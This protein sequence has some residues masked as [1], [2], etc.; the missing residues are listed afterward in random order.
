M[1]LSSREWED[2]KSLLDKAVHKFLG[3]TEQSLVTAAL[4]CIDKGYDKKK[5]ISK[6][7]VFLDD[8]QAEKFSEKLFDVWDDYR[9]KSQR[10]KR[11]DGER[12]R[13]EASEKKKRRFVDDGP[14]AMPV[15]P[16][17]GNP[18]PGQLTG[19][20]IKEMM[21]NAKSMIN[22]RKTQLSA[23]M[24]AP[25]PKPSL[26]G[27]SHNE[28]LMNEALEKVRRAQ[29]LQ[30][31]IQNQM[32][33]LM[34]GKG[35]QPPAIPT[36]PTPLILDAEG[37]TID[38]KTGQTVQL[39]HHTPTLKANIR[40]KRREQFKELIEKPTEEIT[41]GK[42]FD[43]RVGARQAQ[44][45]K[46]G[47]KFHEQGKF[48]AVASRLR[49]KAQLEILQTEIAQAAK[50]TGIASAAKLATIAPKKE[51]REGEIPEVEWWDSYL[52]PKDSY[53]GIVDQLTDE[54]FEGVT[55]LVE[56]PIQLKPPNVPEK[57]PQVPVYLTK[58]ERKKLRR[59]NRQENQKEVT[60]KIRLGLM[61]PP[62]P[63]VRMAN[64]MRVLGTEAVQDPTKVEAHVRAQMAKRQRAHEEANAARKLT[65]EQRRSKKEKKLKEDTSL[66][67]HV[68]VYRLRDLT[69][70]AKKF[71]IEANAKQLYMTGIVIMHKECNVVAV[72]GGPKQQ[73]KFR[74][75]MLQRI[76][77]NEDKHKKSAKD[78]DDSDSEEEQDK[79][80][81]CVLVWE[82]T[83]KQRAFTDLK[84][85]VCPTEAFARE[86][87]KKCGVEQ[88]W[89]LAFSGAVLE[90]T[91]DEDFL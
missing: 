14:V 26:G 75:L 51:L 33:G 80:N 22:E 73:R 32:S 47:F 63:K 17:P 64:L 56:H 68:S 40:A 59:Q 81:K 38:A 78:D 50:K 15:I 43:P 41:V 70:P 49:A 52:L 71:K 66:G 83:T 37:R 44:R 19:D 2:L 39:T 84:F 12:E 91:Q 30:A 58:K 7:E 45:P 89:D 46:R 76:K 54:Q 5:T 55:H 72:E 65:K 90:S 88:Y 24:P 61:P 29:E 57:A 79:S 3:F 62:E 28:I 85:K 69:N 82:G 77:W 10:K 67:V 16:G 4:N 25:P 6:L 35:G 27:L 20:K 13:D 53:E 36:K 42:Y 86:Q 21:A 74:R 18:S 1:S 60:E 34:Q 87:F 48:E 9:N 31:K 11:K 8:R 23:M